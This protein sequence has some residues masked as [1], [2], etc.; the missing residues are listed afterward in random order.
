MLSVECPS[1]CAEC[2]DSS[3]TMICS[4]CKDGYAMDTSGSC[5]SEFGSMNQ[6]F[7]QL[8]IEFIVF[9][10][11]IVMTDKCR[12]IALIYSDYVIESRTVYCQK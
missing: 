12:E 11:N 4:V 8:A 6:W 1:N 2:S 3:G 7:H 5:T 10:L 9:Y